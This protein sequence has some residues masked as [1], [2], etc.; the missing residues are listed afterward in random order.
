MLLRADE[1]KEPTAAALKALLKSPLVNVR[2]GK[3]YAVIT[4]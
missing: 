2:E 1:V 4:T 3:Q